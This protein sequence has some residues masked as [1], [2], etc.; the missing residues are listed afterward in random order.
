MRPLDEDQID[1]LLR[2][3]EHYIDDDGFTNR[4]MSALPPP[5]RHLRPW[6]LFGATLLGALV[7]FIFSPGADILFGAVAEIARYRFE[8]PLPL[9]PL[10]LLGLIVAGATTFLASEED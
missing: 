8:A 5:R 1:A 6:I 9:L 4:V 7:A 2:Q 10:V 3:S